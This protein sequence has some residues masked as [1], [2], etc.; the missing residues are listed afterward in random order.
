[1][2]FRSE[3]FHQFYRSHFNPYLNFHRPCGVP[4]LH[5]NSKGKQKRVYRWYATP[6]EILRQLP[7]LA[8]HLLEEVTQDQLA[9]QAG[10]SSDLQA[11]RNMQK[12]K[13]KL[14]SDLRRRR[15]A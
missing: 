11:A 13:Q 1:M 15:T 8:A 14:F 2:L 9:Q 6:G 5:T 7:D 12:A 3:A 10:T 4:E